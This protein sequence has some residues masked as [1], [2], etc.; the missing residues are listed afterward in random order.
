[1]R[2][3]TLADL[4]HLHTHGGCYADSIGIH[5]LE[6]SSKPTWMWSSNIPG[7]H[8]GP[9]VVVGLR[10]KNITALQVSPRVFIRAERC[11][12]IPVLLQMKK[13]SVWS[14][15]ITTVPYS[16]CSGMHEG[17]TGWKFKAHTHTQTR[18]FS[19]V[20]L[21]SGFCWQQTGKLDICGVTMSFLPQ[22]WSPSQLSQDPRFRRFGRRSMLLLHSSKMVRSWLGAI[23]TM[24]V[25][26][27]SCRVNWRKCRT[28]RQD[29]LVFDKF[30]TQ[31][32]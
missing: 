13:R 20:S 3:V 1:M 11:W 18:M 29:S 15:S 22:A 8:D 21:A 7:Y 24:V 2:D 17:G 19:P 9:W 28:F 4:L 6:K 27:A 23:A 10:K 30:K 25:I 5:S 12:C 14:G 26:V 31:N 32:S 16:S